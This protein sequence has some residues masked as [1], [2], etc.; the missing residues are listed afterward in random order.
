MTSLCRR[1]WRTSE[2]VSAMEDSMFMKARTRCV[3][4]VT[5]PS[6]PATVPSP[7][8]RGER[9]RVRG[10]FFFRVQSQAANPLIRPVGQRRQLNMPTQRKPLPLPGGEGTVKCCHVGDWSHRH[11]LLR[12]PCQFTQA[13]SCD[14]LSA[15]YLQRRNPLSLQHLTP[16]S[17]FPFLRLPSQPPSALPSSSVQC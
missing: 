4:S 6:P 5:V 10:I 11:E 12:P 13:I 16:P 7:P 9:A 3:D 14:S 15:S 1:A 17:D 8:F 2:R